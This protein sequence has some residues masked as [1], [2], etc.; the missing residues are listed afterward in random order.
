AFPPGGISVFA[1]QLHTH[2]AG[3]GVR[4][5]LVRAGR[6][7]EV[8]QEDKHFSTH[9]QGDVLITKCT[10]NTEDRRGPTV[11][12]VDAEHLQKYFSFMN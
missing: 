8:L 5:A 12:H 9:Y 1:S 3:R 6:E 10:Y 7:L 11:S 4:T 2:L